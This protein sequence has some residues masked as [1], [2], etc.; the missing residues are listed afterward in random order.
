M[1]CVDGFVQGLAESALLAPRN[2]GHIGVRREQRSVIK[3][4]ELLGNRTA[5][6]F[7]H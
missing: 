3:L 6:H 5:R 7:T 4:K 1:A 2:N